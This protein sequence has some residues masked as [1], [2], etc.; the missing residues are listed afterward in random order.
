MYS[1]S[2]WKSTLQDC[3]SLSYIISL[4]FYVTMILVNVLNKVMSNKELRTIYGSESKTE[5]SF[6]ASN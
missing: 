5:G 4:S 6:K 2:D 1:S 3:F